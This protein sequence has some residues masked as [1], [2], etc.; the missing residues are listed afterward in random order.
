MMGVK[1]VVGVVYVRWLAVGGGGLSLPHARSLS[2]C[3]SASLT[4]PFP[5]APGS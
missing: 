3:A 2:L 1:E 4:L 5:A